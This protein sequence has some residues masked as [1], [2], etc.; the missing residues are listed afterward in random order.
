VLETF[1]EGVELVPLSLE[2]MRQFT[3]IRGYLQQQGTPI[4]A[5]DLFD[6]GHGAA[7]CPHHRHAQPPPL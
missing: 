7:S 4:G 2:T 5:M 3:I 1:L 6:R